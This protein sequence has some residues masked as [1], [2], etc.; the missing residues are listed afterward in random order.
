MFLPLDQLLSG[1]QSSGNSMG[2]SGTGADTKSLIDEF[3]TNAN[4]NRSR[5]TRE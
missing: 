5:E 1:G 4:R 2:L 3:K